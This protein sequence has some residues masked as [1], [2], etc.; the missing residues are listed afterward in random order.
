MNEM[1]GKGYQELLWPQP[2]VYL[3]TLICFSSL[4]IFLIIISLVS[5]YHI[6]PATRFC[7]KFTLNAK[8]VLIIAALAV[9]YL[10]V[11]YL[12]LIITSL[13]P[14][15]IQLVTIPFAI[16]SIMFMVFALFNT[17][18]C[19]SYTKFSEVQLDEVV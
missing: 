1:E 18:G 19:Q 2:D 9:L 7:Q 6:K 12:N 14:F 5:L 13:N 8:N 11:C 3:I 4:T 15:L 16:G 10:V 17:I